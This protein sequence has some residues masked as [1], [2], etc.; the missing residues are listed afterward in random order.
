MELKRD[1]PDAGLKVARQ[2]AGHANASGGEPILWI[3]GVDERGRRVHGAGGTEPSN[4]WGSVSRHFDEVHPELQILNVPIG[5]GKSVVA[6]H[7]T[8]DRAPYIVG[9]ENGGRVEREVP[10]REGNSTRT[11][12]RSELIRSVISEASVPT[13]EL[14]GGQVD[15]E[16]YAGND[17]PHENPRDYRLGTLRVSTKL[18]MFMSPQGAAYLPEHRQNLRIS[19]LRGGSFDLG[20]FN[21]FGSYRHEGISKF[22]VPQRVAEGGVAIQGRSSI[23]VTGPGQ[24]ELFGDCVL[25]FGEGSELL[26]AR[27]LGLALTMPVDQSDRAARLNCQL[28]V[29][30]KAEFDERDIPDR[31]DS[32]HVARRF[33][34]GAVARDWR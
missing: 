4:W 34:V 24:L 7:F 14:I 25:A 31:Y 10:W 2:V 29:P 1:W 23:D 22:G 12:H 9:V 15:V 5:R 21:L 6:L 33:S 30:A 26:R 13:L 8:S 3:I 16:R 19:T 18:K 11:A 17:G 28:E 32:W 20:T 27:K